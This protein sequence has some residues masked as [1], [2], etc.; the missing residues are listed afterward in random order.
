M[1]TPEFQGTHLFDRLCW[2]KENLEG[3]RSDY[4][5]VFE[6]SVDE[7]AKILVPD[8]NW[9]ACA[10]QGWELAKDEAQPDFKKHTRGYLLHQ[11][12]PVGAMTEEE[13]IEYLI[14]KDVPQHVWKTWNEGNKPKMVICRKERNAWKIAEDINATDLAA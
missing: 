7:C 9:M 12:E 13:A 5:V 8:P 3:V 10:L 2:A 4:R 1:D 6:D 11:T 14:Q